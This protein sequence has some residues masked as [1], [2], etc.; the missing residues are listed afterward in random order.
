LS[1]ELNSYDPI[2]L[3]GSSS[4]QS[5]IL[6]TA[7]SVEPLFVSGISDLLLTEPS[8]PFL[9]VKPGSLTPG[10]PYQFTFS[11][12]NRYG[13]GTLFLFF[14]Y[15]EAPAKVNFIPI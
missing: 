14:C 11:V 5:P 8:S 12:T 13:T 10:I 9:A 15:K 1:G 4:S 6:N 7:W 3:E 2:I